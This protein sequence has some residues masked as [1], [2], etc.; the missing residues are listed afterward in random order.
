ME[1]HPIP[2]DVT[3]FQFKLIGDM[4]VKQFAYIAVGSVLAFVFFYA[5]M[6]PFI[7]IPIGVLFG[8]VGAALAF[9]PIEGRPAD[10]MIGYFIKA[11]VTPNQYAY[12]K[13]GGSIALFTI[14]SMRATSHVPAKR[15]ATPVVDE[16]KAQRL[17]EYLQSVQ[18]PTS[19]HLDVR[20]E[21]FLQHVGTPM[22]S[23]QPA[24]SQY[25]P[26]K[27]D[28]LL[29]PKEM[30]EQEANLA[31]QAASVKYALNEAKDHEAKE[32]DAAKAHSSHEQVVELEKKLQNLLAQ[33][34]QVEKELQALKGERLAH[35]T[36]A[37]PP[38]TQPLPS[39]EAEQLAQQVAQQLSSSQPQQAAALKPVAP[40][41]KPPPPTPSPSPTIRK[42]P[43][44]MAKSIG[45]PRMPEVPNLI[46]GIV[47]DPRDNVLQNILV[48]VRDKDGTP[49]RAFRTNSLG[50]F[51]S[52]TPLTNGTYTIEFE[53]PKGQHRFDVVELVANGEVI[54]PLEITS[55]DEREELR[56]AL[57]S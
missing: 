20:E 11:L 8:I 19:S 45:L 49:A 18:K 47:K 28:A 41:V 12:H 23:P 38:Q 2:Q 55:H 6:T 51:A 29:T 37:T 4:T 35:T 36:S 54:L 48:E 57:F 10:A 46:V 31:L 39:Q 14:P 5:P 15:Q 42:I 50:Q 17:Q 40:A 34:D 25:Q 33:K 9:L 26:K 16:D 32:K 24:P 7:K 56:K 13:L 22:P 27:A 44:D 1:N 3:G 21:E 53:D 43:A 52:A 30:E